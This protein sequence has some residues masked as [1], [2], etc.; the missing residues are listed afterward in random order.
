MSEWKLF[1]SETPYVATLDF[2]RDRDRAPH[3]EQPDHRARLQRCARLIRNISP[4]SVVDLGCGDGGLLS[5]IKDIPSWG[6]DFQPSNEPAWAERGVTA[7][8]R[9]VFNTRDVPRWGELAVLTEVL[10]HLAD[11]HGTAEWVSRHAAWIVASSPRHESADF[12]GDCHAWAWDEGG[13]EALIAPHFEVERHET[14][15]WSQI[16]VGRSKRCASSSA[17]TEAS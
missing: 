6:Y 3:L 11:P 13:Y 15:D 1:D 5:L 16:I 12:H 9:D 17:D 8:R 10:E 14:V 2:H 4:A 7:E